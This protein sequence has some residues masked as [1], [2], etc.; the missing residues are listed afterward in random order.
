MG[1]IN[2][3]KSEEE[4]EEEVR[5]EDRDEKEEAKAMSDLVGAS[6][7]SGAAFLR[8]ISWCTMSKKFKMKFNEIPD[9]LV[10]I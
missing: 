10:S 9:S 3:G 6:G 1:L 8:R 4:E 2:G 7:D 5:R